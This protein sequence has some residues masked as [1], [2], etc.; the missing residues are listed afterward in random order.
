MPKSVQE[1]DAEILKYDLGVN[2]V[3]TSHY[4]QSAISESL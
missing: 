4:M 3:R 1:K 2:I